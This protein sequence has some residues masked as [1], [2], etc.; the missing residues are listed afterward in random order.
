MA[1]REL[2]KVEWICDGCGVTETIETD[3]VSKEDLPTGWNRIRQDNNTWMD[4]CMDCQR[5][6]DS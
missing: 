4:L 3:L 5:G 2:H 1:Y 6:L